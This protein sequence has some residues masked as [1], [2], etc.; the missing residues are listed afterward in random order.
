MNM[1]LKV[2][3]DQVKTSL[4]VLLLLAVQQTPVVRLPKSAVALLFVDLCP[5]FIFYAYYSC[6]L[7]GN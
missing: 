5:V 2:K 7:F 6:W 1:C 3:I 4:P